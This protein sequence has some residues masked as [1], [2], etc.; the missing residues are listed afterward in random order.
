MVVL[1]I[2]IGGTK[3]L[4]TLVDGPEVVERIEAPTERSAGPKEWVDQVAAMAKQLKGTFD[5][6]GITVSGLVKDNRWSAM[7]A[8]TLTIPGRF[9][10]L[11]VAERALDVPVTLC[12]DAQAAA[13]G[14]F[15][16]GAG[17][18]KD[19]V[20]LTISTG[21]GGGVVAN[22]RLLSGRG[23]VAG[24]FGQT[25]PQPDGDENLFEDCS[26]GRW[27]AAQGT[28]LGLPLDTRAVFAAAVNGNQAAEKVIQTSAN[29]VGRL[30]HN[31]QLM[32]DP[33]VTVIGGGVGMAPGFLERMAA[34]VEHFQ[35]LVRPTFVEAKL[36]DD[37]GVIGVADLSKTTETKGDFQ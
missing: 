15:V 27:I 11:E 21:V 28:H 29:R 18:N 37:A 8:E 13:W 35:P 31:L 19:I 30:C 23:G 16:H 3:T 5:R 34:S 22:G 25:L 24:H 26:S 12:N 6:A 36:K 17:Q 10:L 9:A 7:N 32:F 20:F 1:A 14:E 4:V 2:D 33:H